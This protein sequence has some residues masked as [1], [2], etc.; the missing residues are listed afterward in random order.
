[1]AEASFLKHHI[2]NTFFLIV[3]GEG[4]EPSIGYF[5]LRGP[6]T[7][8]V[9]RVNLFFFSEKYKHGHVTRLYFKDF[10]KK[11]YQSNSSVGVDGVRCNQ[12]FNFVA[13]N[14]LNPLINASP[15]FSWLKSKIQHFDIFVENVL[16][17]RA[18][19]LIFIEVKT[20]RNIKIIFN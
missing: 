10:Q 5:E 18:N 6:L 8:K 2:G 15:R 14:V 17:A 13:R 1:V 19:V 16:N 9:S 20:I 4:G 7:F 12:I 3:D 11:N